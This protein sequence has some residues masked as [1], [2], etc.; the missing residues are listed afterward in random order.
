MSRSPYKMRMDGLANGIAKLLDGVPLEDIAVA[1]AAVI[2][3]ALQDMRPEQRVT[4]RALVDQ[5]IKM[6]S[7]RK[8]AHATH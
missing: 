5:T 4:V 1:C 6:Q 7:G 8:N 2:G 3:D